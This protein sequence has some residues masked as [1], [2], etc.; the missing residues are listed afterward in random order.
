[1][2]PCSHVIQRIVTVSAPD[3]SVAEEAFQLVANPEAARLFVSLAP[4][5]VASPADDSELVASLGRGVT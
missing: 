1:M 4:A 3:D 5:I 2:A